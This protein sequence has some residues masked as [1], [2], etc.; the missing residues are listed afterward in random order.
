MTISTAKPKKRGRKRKEDTQSVRSGT[1]R[2][3]PQDAAS[4]TSQGGVGDDEQDAEDDDEEADRAADDLV[5]T[6]A[7][8]NDEHEQQRIAV[9]LAAFDDDQS[10]RYDLHR[11]VKLRKETVRKIVN[12]TLS[13]SV[14]PSVITTINGYTKV[15]LASLIERARDIQ[16]QSVLA[17]EK[18]PSPARS[19][20]TAAAG[21]T[22][23]SQQ[24]QQASID[25][26]PIKTD[27]GYMGPLIPDHFRE[28]YRRYRRDGEGGGA[29]VDGRS[30][31]LGVTGTASARLGGRRLFK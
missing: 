16:E 6:G 18:Y 13:Q 10:E 30:V 8:V 29:G 12:Q 3:T 2:G 9:L 1:A 25:G 19:P 27:S 20:A 5:Q 28:A 17:A 11:R 14:P 7:K 22:L 4:R 15:F 23:A 26:L 21:I 31:G 24:N